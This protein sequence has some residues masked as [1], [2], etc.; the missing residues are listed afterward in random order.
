[1]G[2]FEVLDILKRNG[3]MT[4]DG[5]EK[6]LPMMSR[7]SILRCVRALRKYR[8]VKVEKLPLQNGTINHVEVV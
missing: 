3:A 5:L 8:L 4:A 7:A 2:Q 6:A 1:M